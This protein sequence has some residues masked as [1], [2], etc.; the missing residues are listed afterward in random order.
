ML[1]ITS[2]IYQNSMDNFQMDSPVFFY[3]PTA[4]AAATTA[5]AATGPDATTDAAAGPITA[6]PPATT[7]APTAATATAQHAKRTGGSG[8]YYNLIMTLAPRLYASS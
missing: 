2:G 5:D 4:P 6:R 1:A 7:A 8:T 3:V